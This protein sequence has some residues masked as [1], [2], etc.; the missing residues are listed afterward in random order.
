MFGSY[1]VLEASKKYQE[2]DKALFSKTYKDNETKFQKENKYED[3]MANIETLK[4]YRAKLEK[5]EKD[6]KASKTNKK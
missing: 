4:D 6:Q 5:H 3:Y 1:V 2:A